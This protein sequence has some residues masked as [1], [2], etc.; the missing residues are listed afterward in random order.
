MTAAIELFDEAIELN[1]NFGAAYHERG[2]AKLL[3]G[4]KDGSIEDM[5]KSLE[6]N[7]KEGENLNGQFNNQ[8]AETPQTYWDCKLTVLIQS[9][10]GPEPYSLSGK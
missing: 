4:D 1:P 3:N 8:Q 5:K 7:P 10:P 9:F 6:L 2:R